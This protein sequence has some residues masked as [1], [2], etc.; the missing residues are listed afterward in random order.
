MNL[1]EKKKLSTRALTYILLVFILFGRVLEAWSK[2]KTSSAVSALGSLRPSTGQLLLN[3][4]ASLSSAVKS[5]QVELL[6]VGDLVLIPSGSSPPLDCNLV[7][8]A[9]NPAASFLESAITGESRSVIKA[10][11][12]VLYSGTINQSKTAVIARVTTLAG[13]NLIDNVIEIVQSSSSRKADIEQLADKVTSHFVPIIVAISIITLIIWLAVLYTPGTI[14][15]EWRAKHIQNYQQCGAQVLFALQFA[16]SV[17]VVACPCGIG[18]AAPTAQIIAIGLASKY[19]ILVQGGG[20]AFQSA[21]QLA[22]RKKEKAYIFDKTGTI[23][24][25]NDGSNVQEVHLEKLPGTWSED[26]LWKA[27]WLVEGNSSHPIAE[28]IRKWSENKADNEA[29]VQIDDI[30][31]IAGRGLK[32]TAKQGNLLI[33]SLSLIREQSNIGVNIATEMQTKVNEWQSKGASVVYIAVQPRLSEEKQ[34]CH[35]V[36]ALSMADSIRADAAFTIAALKER[37]RGQ[38]WMVSGDTI[39]TAKAIAVQVGITPDNVIAGVLPAEKAEW[40]EKIKQANGDDLESKRRD[41]KQK[42]TLTMFVGDGINDAP[43]LSC[44]DLSIAL[45]SGSTLATSTASF[46]LLN[47]DRPLASIP[48]I[49]SLSK[50]TQNKIWQNLA[51]ACAFNLIFIPIAAGVFVQA[52]FN[53]GPSWSGLAMALSSVSVVLNA[54]T[55]RL[56]RPPRMS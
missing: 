26:A 22:N 41:L 18:L 20:Q 44:A 10:E 43:A 51:W 25:G 12:D 45:G 13:S 50:A 37:Y 33:G 6:E 32:A 31:E 19:G 16:V 14:S 52:G 30:E 4:E 56:W 46:I 2:R 7:G 27:V 15:N 29:Q 38:A 39:S 3:P 1:V 11:G 42:Q 40:V 8:T 36:A 48:V 17:L 21:V 9:S 5:V 54:L 28:G 34:G 35:V 24:H 49:L 23:T 47:Q 53:F 55:L